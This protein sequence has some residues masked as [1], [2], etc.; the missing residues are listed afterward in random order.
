M[1]KAPENNAI[2]RK[3]EIFVDM[4]VLKEND[5][6]NPQKSNGSL[7]SKAK[8]A[9][10]LQIKEN[11]NIVFQKR[12][13]E[14]KTLSIIK[15]NRCLVSTSIIMGFFTLMVYWAIAIL[16]RKTF[17]TEVEVP[18][19]FWKIVFMDFLTFNE[20]LVLN[21]VSILLM[22]IC[23]GILKTGGVYIGPLLVSHLR[24]SAARSLLYRDN[25][26]QAS[27]PASAMNELL[28]AKSAQVQ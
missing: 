13:N 20:V 9:K 5:Y 6:C 24:I 15:L 25:N 3:G 23:Y 26:N 2:T 12:E 11:I 4:P 10:M 18:S 21:F 19:S 22:M 8:N 1:N 16:I 14:K 28:L 17:I 27:I 7:K